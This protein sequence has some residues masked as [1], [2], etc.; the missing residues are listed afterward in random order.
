MFASYH[1][2][3]AVDR[4]VPYEKTVNE[5]RAPTDESVRLLREMEDKARAQVA[6][7]F[8]TQNNELVR[9]AV[10]VAQ[11]ADMCGYSVIVTFRL[12]GKDVLV[13]TPL[14]YMD[15][16]LDNREAAK[17]LLEAMAS[18]IVDELTTPVLVAVFVRIGER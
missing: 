15:L 2:N 5:H 7:A 8:V 4:L 3:P 6:Q 17:K 16:M 11:R 18:K 13:E 10:S 14:L 1:I 12:N 9:G